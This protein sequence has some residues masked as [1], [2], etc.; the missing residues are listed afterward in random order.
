[1][2]RLFAVSL[3]S[4][5]MAGAALA[6]PAPEESWGKAGITLDQYRQDAL[7]CG[8]QGYYTDI[9]KTED[10]KEFVRAS[11]RLDT[12]T[13]G[14]NSPNTTG[15]GGSGPVST[16]SVQQL[17]TYAADQQHVVDSLHPE[18]R[19]RSIKKTLESTTERCL[20]QRGYSKFALTD[21]QRRKL[22]HLKAGSDERRAYLYSLASNPAVLQSQRA[23]AQP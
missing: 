6:A 14:S 11:R 16:D 17:A 19:F 13:T 3:I 7:D 4:T 12:M 20:I 8:L 5:A 1:M 18:E 15:A 23:T 9:S 22:R 10:A 21:E 2:R